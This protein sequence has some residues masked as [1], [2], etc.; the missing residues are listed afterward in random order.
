MELVTEQD[1]I[2]FIGNA[3]VIDDLKFIL[4]LSKQTPMSR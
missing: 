4:E 3:L 1:Y 2:L